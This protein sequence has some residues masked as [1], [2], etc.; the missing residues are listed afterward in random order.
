[1]YV[2]FY[3]FDMVFVK[4][5][6]YNSQP[7]MKKTTLMLTLL[8][9]CVGIAQAQV[10]AVDYTIVNVKGIIKRPDGKQLAKGQKVNVN[11]KIKFSKDALM[12]IT[13]AAK[14]TYSVIEPSVATA[15]KIELDF[16]LSAFLTISKKTS[17]S[18]ANQSI[19]KATDEFAKLFKDKL[20][21]VGT[22]AKFGLSGG[23]DMDEDHFF[24]VNGKFGIE[25]LNKQVDFKDSLLIITKTLLSDATAKPIASDVD[26]FYLDVKVGEALPICKVNITF[27]D[28]ILF[29]PK[30]Q[31][32]VDMY[33]AI[34]GTVIVKADMP[35]EIA[36]YIT[37]YYGKTDLDNLTEWINKNLKI[38]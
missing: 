28:D 18:K 17:A 14:K 36:N 7:L 30:L 38:L 25:T 20:F 10:P 33:A 5:F 8:L 13:D 9:F 11:D 12:L 34:T 19:I 29:K 37:Q 24:Y 23:F 35:K 1:M 3:S 15:T 4:Y 16:P 27:I 2:V 31:S 21:I 22:E 32:I 6:I 26:M